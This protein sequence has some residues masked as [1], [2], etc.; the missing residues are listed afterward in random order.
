MARTPRESRGSSS[1]VGRRD[2]SRIGAVETRRKDAQRRGACRNPGAQPT[3]TRRAKW[4]IISIRRK[5]DLIC[6]KFVST[7]RR[8]TWTPLT[9][10]SEIEKAVSLLARNP[11]IGHLRRDLT[12]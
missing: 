3:T 5:R 1:E 6:W 4:L 2:R 8:T 9:G 12:S 10:L 11:E 7:S